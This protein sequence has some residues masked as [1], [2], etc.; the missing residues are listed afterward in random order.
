MSLNSHAKTNESTTS[1]FSKEFKKSAAIIALSLATVGAGVFARSLPA[2]E[3]I[4]PKIASQAW[5][6]IINQNSELGAPADAYVR[7]VD[8]APTTPS[9]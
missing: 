2:Q 8:P 5:A 1:G 4:I 3:A 6:L 9:Q 7:F